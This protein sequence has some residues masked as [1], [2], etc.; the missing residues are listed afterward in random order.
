MR[1]G[2][3]QDL[4]TE[5]VERVRHRGGKNDSAG[6]GLRNGKEGVA[7]NQKKNAQV[8]LIWER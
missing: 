6:P 3:M 2:Q 8:E 1:T 5:W 4:L 7:M